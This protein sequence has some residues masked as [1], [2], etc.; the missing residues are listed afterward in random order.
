MGPSVV[1]V[2]TKTGAQ[3]WRTKEIRAES[4]VLADGYVIATHSP[5]NQPTQ[6]VVL[7]GDTGKV[8]SRV[9]MK[10]QTSRYRLV[11]DK[12]FLYGFD[13]VMSCKFA[14]E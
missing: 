6:I 7:E 9:T 5:Y 8:V 1:A 4:L 2:D 11:L 3:L 12:G 13:G 14:V 10:G